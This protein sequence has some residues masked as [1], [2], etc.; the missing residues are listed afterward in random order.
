MAYSKMSLNKMTYVYLH[1]GSSMSSLYN[2]HP[3]YICLFPPSI[4]QPSCTVINTSNDSHIPA[5]G[6]IFKMCLKFLH[7]YSVLTYN[8]YKR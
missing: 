7:Y 2:S 8:L 5:L 4:H 6:P 1:K 3:S